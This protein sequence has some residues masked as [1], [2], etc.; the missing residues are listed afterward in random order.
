MIRNRQSR[1]KHKDIIGTTAVGL[2]GL[3]TSTPHWSSASS[4]EKRKLIQD[5]IKSAEEENTD[6]KQSN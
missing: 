5:G 3:G 6:Q 1:H 2:Q 4:R